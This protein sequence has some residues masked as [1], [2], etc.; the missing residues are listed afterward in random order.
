MKI[1]NYLSLASSLF[2]LLSFSMSFGISLTSLNPIESKLISTYSDKIFTL[3][4]AILFLGA[5]ISNILIRFLSLPKKTSLLFS[6]I[7]LI[8]GYCDILIRQNILNVITGRILIGLAVGIINAIIPIYLSSIAPPNL[9]AV[10]C[11]LHTFALILGIV[12]GYAMILFL[13]FSQMYITI[14]VFLLFH[15]ILIMFLRP[16]SNSENHKLKVKDIFRI[17][18]NDSSR[19]AAYIFILL[20]AGQHLSGINHIVIFL[21]RIFPHQYAPIYVNLFAAFTTGLSSFFLAGL[22]LKKMT[23]LSSFMVA[24]S[25]IL[26]SSHLNDTVAIILFVLG[27]NLGLNSIPWSIISVLF[28]EEFIEA[29]GIIGISTN[30]I[31]SF[32]SIYMIAYLQEWFGSNSVLFYSLSMIIFFILILFTFDEKKMLNTTSDIKNKEIPSN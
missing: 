19:K 28:N 26:Y 6:N 12:A 25:F 22:G 20:H 24:F 13:G 7:L 5:L 10:F 1:Q 2:I 14:I 18:K 17:F 31:S 15:T 3:S 23:L 29:A 11:T 8:S 4:V 30:Y 27:F 21:K 9:K 16:C 32:L